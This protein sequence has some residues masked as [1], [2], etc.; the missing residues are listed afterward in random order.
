M[1]ENIQALKDE[2]M[3]LQHQL[4]EER[5]TSNALKG[6]VA[7]LN[8][9]AKVEGASQCQTSSQAKLFNLHRGSSFTLPQDQISK[10]ICTKTKVKRTLIPSLL[11]RM[12]AQAAFN[13]QI[14]G[15][16]ILKVRFLFCNYMKLFKYV[17][18]ENMFKLN[19][20]LM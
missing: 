10:S 7:Q 2:K 16:H 6:E 1:K 13:L 17:D 14:I 11:T 4:E 9:Q 15:F 20:K 12:N 8:K 18:L 3:H 5:V 19:Y